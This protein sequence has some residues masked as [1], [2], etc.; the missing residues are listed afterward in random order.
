MSNK[1]KFDEAK[2]F[3][4]VKTFIKVISASIKDYVSS[5]SKDNIPNKDASLI[6]MQ[7]LSLLCGFSRGYT[8]LEINDLWE[9]SMDLSKKL[10]ADQFEDKV[11]DKFQMPPN[12]KYLN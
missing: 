8:N 4:D 6:A 3:D 10:Y 11:V 9:K 1:A 5:V 2:Q 12:S 7:V